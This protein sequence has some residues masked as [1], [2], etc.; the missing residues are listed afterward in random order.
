[1]RTIILFFILSTVLFS[2]EKDDN[3][4]TTLTNNEISGDWKIV[5]FIDSGK[6]ETNHFQGYTFNF[7]LQQVTATNGTIIVIG[8]YNIQNTSSGGSKLILNFNETDP[9]EELN[10]DWDVIEKSASRIKLR[11]VSGGNGGTDE[12]IF[13]KS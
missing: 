6:D 7:I 5:S 9:W 11:H 13:Q 2:C 8:N 4:T 1:M 10:E 3:I 12:L